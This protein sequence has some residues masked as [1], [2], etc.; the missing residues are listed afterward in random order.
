M[1]MGLYIYRHVIIGIE[2]DTQQKWEAPIANIGIENNTRQKEVKLHHKE[3]LHTDI[4]I[5]KRYPAVKGALNF[6]GRL[7]AL[8]PWVSKTIPTH[9]VGTPNVNTTT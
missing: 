7:L 6:S 9:K 8:I 5:K 3:M 1:R 4:G 2:N